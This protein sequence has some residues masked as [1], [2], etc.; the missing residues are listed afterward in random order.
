M[1]DASVE[2]GKVQPLA[3]GGWW[4]LLHTPAA[5]DGDTTSQ[6]QFLTA[7]TVDAQ[8]NVII[9]GRGVDGVALGSHPAGSGTMYLAKFSPEGTPR[10]ARR[11]GTTFGEIRALTTS[12]SG[13]ILAL[14]V[15]RAGSN[16][17]DLGN[18]PLPQYGADDIFVGAFTAQGELRWTYTVGGTSYD[19][20]GDLVVAPDGRI[21]IGADVDRRSTLISLSEDG[22]VLFDQRAP[23]GISINA[24][25]GSPVA[26]IDLDANGNVYLAGRS[27]AGLNLG[28]GPTP[29]SKFEVGWLASYS[30]ADGG[31][32]WGHTFPTTAGNTFTGSGV[33][34]NG[35]AVLGDDVLVAG[36][37][38]LDVEL[39]G[40]VITGGGALTNTVFLAWFDAATGKRR[41][42]AKLSTPSTLRGMTKGVQGNVALTLKAEGPF[43]DAARTVTFDGSPSV[44]VLAPHASLPGDG[45]IVG[46]RPLPELQLSKAI[47]TPHPGPS[48]VHLDS[49]GNLVFSVDFLAPE[50][51]SFTT[52]ED[53][54]T[55]DSML[56]RLP[57]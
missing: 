7:T 38:P 50:L 26:A 20:A 22:D 11:F 30:G 31:Y 25:G 57:W 3:D 56:V 48:K 37:F 24:S 13:D 44:L 23:A 36:G 10:W 51:F 5:P 52:L 34:V 40:A 32:R 49:A 55:W 21:F 33:S 28:G 45:S 41:A 42:S 8:D 2:T 46:H 18:G 19:G 6:F 53:L 16:P 17:M 43:Y 29:A 39:D 15:Y 35:L 14:G 1:P 47:L 12:P 27:G 9:A 54:H 4:F